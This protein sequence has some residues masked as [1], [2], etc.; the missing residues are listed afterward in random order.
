MRHDQLVS[1]VGVAGI[2]ADGVHPGDDLVKG[3]GIYVVPL[4]VDQDRVIRGLA[5]DALGL[6]V[7]TGRFG[8][9]DNGEGVAPRLGVILAELV[10]AVNG[11]QGEIGGIQLRDLL[12]GAVLLVAH[13]GRVFVGVFALPVGG[14]DHRDARPRFDL[15]RRVVGHAGRGGA[16]H[17]DRVQRDG[18]HQHRQ[19]Q[20]QDLPAVFRCVLFHDAS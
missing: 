13:V 20:Q 4:G 14:L 7:G 1:G 10:P 11:F 18:A 17:N 12:R 5:G 19:A 9:V 15:L 6:S 16:V 3:A 8:D 2:A